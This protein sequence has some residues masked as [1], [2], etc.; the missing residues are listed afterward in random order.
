MPSTTPKKE[1][2]FKTKKLIGK[3]CRFLYYGIRYAFSIITTWLEYD[4]WSGY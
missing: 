1:I 3:I 4:H 2:S